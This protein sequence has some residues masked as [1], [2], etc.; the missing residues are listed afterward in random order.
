L[1]VEDGR[2]LGSLNRE[3]WGRYDATIEILNQ[4]IF[5]KHATNYGKNSVIVQWEVE[6]KIMSFWK[7][8]SF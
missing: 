4:K 5:W 8:V 1:V 7:Y 6:N 2:G 3:M